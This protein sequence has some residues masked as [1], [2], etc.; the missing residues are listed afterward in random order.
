LLSKAC[1]SLTTQSGHDLLTTTSSTFTTILNTVAP[2]ISAHETL[3]LWLS[4]P[5]IGYAG[6]EGV[7]YRA[8]TRILEQTQS[9]E[10]IVIWSPSPL[11]AE[12]E[13]K[14]GGRSINPLEGWEKG[15]ESALSEMGEV[16]KREED[17]QGRVRTA[18]RESLRRIPG[19]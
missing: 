9:G 2:P 5:M 14:D 12:K 3:E 15:W 13:E 16:K 17:P 4:H 10:L 19:S 1:T 6:V 11:T 18:N 7:V 8:W